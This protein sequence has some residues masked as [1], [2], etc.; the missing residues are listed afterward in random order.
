MQQDSASKNLYFKKIVGE[1]LKDIRK[2]T[3]TCSLSEFA[4]QYDIDRSNLSKIERGINNCTLSTVWRVVEAT[5]I[6]F[7]EFAKRLE[8]KLG[9]DFQLMDE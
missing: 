3:T 8:E 9:N 2:E 7:S 4:R 6:S 5:N 1:V